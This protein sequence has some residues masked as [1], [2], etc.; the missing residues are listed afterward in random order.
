MG[1]QNTVSQDL[2]LFLLVL[3]QGQRTYIWAKL[4]SFIRSLGQAENLDNLTSMRPW[5]WYKLYLVNH[6]QNVCPP[7]LPDVRWESLKLTSFRLSCNNNFSKVIQ[8]NLYLKLGDERQ[9]VFID[10]YIAGVPSVDEVD[11]V[12]ANKI[13]PCSRSTYK[14]NKYVFFTKMSWW[15]LRKNQGKS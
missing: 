7:S 10:L 13:P 8:L 4:R 11:Q 9:K 12:N 3:K 15:K 2:H 1:S 5:P 14:R 6:L